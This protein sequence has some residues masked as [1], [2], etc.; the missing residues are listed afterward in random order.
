MK[1]KATVVLTSLPRLTL[2]LVHHSR[3]QQR[4]HS[5]PSVPQHSKISLLTFPLV[6]RTFAFLALTEMSFGVVFTLP[7]SQPVV[8]ESLRINWLLSWKWMV[9][10]VDSSTFWC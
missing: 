1:T 6:R 8:S 5:T 3:S 7:P 9:L 2:S 4:P 10:A